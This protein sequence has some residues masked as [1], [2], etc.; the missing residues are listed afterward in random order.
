[1]GPLVTTACGV[2]GSQMEWP[3]LFNFTLEFAIRKV[4]ENQVRLKLNWTH[5]LLAYADDVNLLEY[6]IDTVN[7]NTK[8]LIDANKEVG[9]EVNIEKT[10]YILVSHY[11]NGDK[12]RDIKIAN[13][14]LEN[15]SQFKHLGIT[16]TIKI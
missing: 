9:R 13:R 4:Q 7:K 16:V 5:Q 12:N 1:V 2:L 10:K 8:T 11:Q 15:V 3:L 6:N 14:S